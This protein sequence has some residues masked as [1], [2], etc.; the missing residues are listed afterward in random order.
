MPVPAVA[1]DRREPPPRSRSKMAPRSHWPPSEGQPPEGEPPGEEA[2]KPG[3][4]P[5][6][7]TPQDTTPP[8]TSITGGTGIDDRVHLGEAFFFVA[9]EAG[10]SFECSL[11]GADWSSCSSPTTYAGLA[12]SSHQF[13]VRARDPAGNVDA[14]PAARQLDDRRH[15]EPEPPVDNTPPQTSIVS[16]PAKNTTSTIGQLLTLLDRA[17]ID[18]RL[19]P[20]RRRLG[21]LRGDTDLFRT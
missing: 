3:E 7:E 1:K 21:I 19:Q 2:G 13:A 9:S 20:R 8:E 14:T 17:R 15:S 12:L 6:E 11:D 16:G 10:S 5:G 18:L 4:P